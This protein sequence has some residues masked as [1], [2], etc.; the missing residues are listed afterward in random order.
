MVWL[1]LA[2]LV[3]V[4]VAI[5][6]DLGV[7]NR[8][9][10]VMGTREGLAWTGVWVALALVFNGLIY[11]I[12]RYDWLGASDAGP[13]GGTAAVEFFAGYLIEK[14]LSLDNIFVIALIFAYFKVPRENQHRVLY[15]GILGALILRGIMI[16]V[17]AAMIRRFDWMSYVF[18][19]ILLVTAARML[20]SDHD[21]VE[22][23]HNP[24]VRLA[25]RMFPVTDRFRGEHFFVRENGR[26][27][28]T[29]LLIVLI[30]IE[31][32]D[33][34]FAVDSIPAVFAVTRD[35]F[36]V[37][38]SNVFAVLGLRA[39]YF[40]LADIIDRFR[41]LKVSLVVVLAFV[42]TKMLLS[43]RVPIPTL[44]SLGVIAA[45]LTTGIVASVI[46]NRR[47]LRTTA[48]S[49]PDAGKE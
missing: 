42:G 29:P 36:I 10:H 22:P 39:L 28:A 31:S 5:C 46:V 30:V 23:E 12:Y 48:A 17:G 21:K 43:H 9:A 1:W 27:M 38:T 40:V 45:I 13:S 14:S 6:V 15:L 33:V 20:F 34:L 11:F 4:V 44:V 3:F 49:T 7:F 35:P 2:F 25:R 26:R 47:E 24:L 32:T 41:Y 18:G 37:F 8:R 16:G 19:A